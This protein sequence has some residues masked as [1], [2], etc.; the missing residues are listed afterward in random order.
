LSDLPQPQAE[1]RDPRGCIEYCSGKGALDP[2]QQAEDRPIGRKRAKKAVM[3]VHEEK[4]ARVV[5]LSVKRLAALETQ[6]EI[7]ITSKELYKMSE[8]A[9]KYFSNKP[10][11]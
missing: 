7:D 4:G 6:H 3:E 1:G 11:F 8:P 9:R 10:Q 2:E 5:E